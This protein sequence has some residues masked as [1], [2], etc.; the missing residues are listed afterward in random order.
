MNGL[1]EGAGRSPHAV[2]AA[3]S[4]GDGPER[5]PG[6]KLFTPEQE[7]EFVR[8]YQRNSQH[9]VKDIKTTLRQMNHGQGLG[10]SYFK[11]ASWLVKRYGL[12]EA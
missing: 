10:N 4:V 7:Q 6:D 1:A 3:A 8:R 9:G 11:H 2:P 5:G 12:R